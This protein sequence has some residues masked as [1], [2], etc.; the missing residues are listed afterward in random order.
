M[1]LN[2]VFILSYPRFIVK[3]PSD[4]WQTQQ[5]LW[6]F[7]F[8]NTSFFFFFLQECP[9]ILSHFYRTRYMWAGRHLN[10]AR[11]YSRSLGHSVYVRWLL[12][13]CG[14]K[15]LSSKVHSSPVA[16]NKSTPSVKVTLLCFYCHR[17]LLACSVS[18]FRSMTFSNMAFFLSLPAILMIASILPLSQEIGNMLLQ[19]PCNAFE[20]TKN[21][22]VCASV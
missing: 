21:C 17:S 14:T 5:G 4:S 20:I 1:H 9:V 13:T 8:L 19:H 6:F 12:T 18:T 15:V 7:V 2:P 22:S 3:L 11:G 16:K 10:K